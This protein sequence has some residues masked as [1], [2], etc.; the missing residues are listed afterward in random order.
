MTAKL[1]SQE[2]FL[3]LWVCKQKRLHHVEEGKYNALDEIA[4]KGMFELL[5]FGTY[6]CLATL[7]GHTNYVQCL[8]F[9]GNKLFSAGGGDGTIRVWNVKED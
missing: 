7:E 2:R 9:Y 5:F 3:V 4:L 8:T 1:T 6:K